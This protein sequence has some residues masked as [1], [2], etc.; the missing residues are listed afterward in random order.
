MKGNRFL[1]NWYRQILKNPDYACE[2][3]LQ[4]KRQIRTRLEQA[5]GIVI[6]GAGRLGDI[7]FR[8]L[9]NEGYSE[10]FCCFAVSQKD[11][12]KTMAGKQVL[13]IIEAV[14]SFPGALLI[15]AVDRFS[16][17]HEQMKETLAGMGISCYLDGSDI[18]ENFYII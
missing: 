14:E 13:S 18:E 6:Y 17:I 15:L 2:E 11:S 12:E 1:E 8:G 9:H 4:K 16:K 5:E 3:I 10:K 7:V